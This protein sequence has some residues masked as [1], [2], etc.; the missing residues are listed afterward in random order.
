MFVHPWV[1]AFMGLG[2]WVCARVSVT[3][4]HTL[5]ESRPRASPSPSK[6]ETEAGRDCRGGHTRLGQ[7]TPVSPNP[8]GLE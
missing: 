7:P 6:G 8:T 2:L 3:H 5:L 4:E 1:R